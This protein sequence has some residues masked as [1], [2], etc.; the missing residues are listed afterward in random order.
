MHRQ[1]KYELGNPNE[2]WWCNSHNRRATHI[3]NDAYH[4]CKPG[5]SGIL[6]SC[7]AVN[8]TDTLEVEDDVNSIKP[9]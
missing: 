8:I 5:Q 3:L 2:Y 4:V 7:M 6:L 1:A 9:V